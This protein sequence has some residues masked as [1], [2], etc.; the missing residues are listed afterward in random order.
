MIHTAPF[1]TGVCGDGGGG[2]GGNDSDM[3]Q[4]IGTRWRRLSQCLTRPQQ[5]N[6]NSIS[7][8]LRSS[9]CRTHPGV[10]L[11]HDHFLEIPLRKIRFR[12][13][14]AAQVETRSRLATVVFMCKFKKKIN[15]IDG[16]EVKRLW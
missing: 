2:Q 16:G 12:R 14:H 15:R 3:T 8:N 13:D 11:G 9:F 4:T 7:R 6:V 1:E 10:S 5:L